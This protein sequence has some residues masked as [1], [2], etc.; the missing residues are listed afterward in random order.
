MII[1][2]VMESQGSQLAY[3]LK[4]LHGAMKYNVG[5]EAITEPFLTTY[6]F[7]NINS[8]NINVCKSALEVASLVAQSEKLGFVVADRC[9]RQSSLDNRPYSN[10]VTAL[11]STDVGIQANALQLINSLYMTVPD[12]QS[13]KC[14]SLPS[15]SEMSSVGNWID[16]SE[17]TRPYSHTTAR[18]FLRFVCALRH[19]AC[20]V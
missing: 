7:P 13:Q 16:P 8:P 14:T 4:A 2:A 20:I 3:A 17:S 19:H 9:I 18:F 5:Y 11:S 1:H 12:P 6:L 15:F 10:I